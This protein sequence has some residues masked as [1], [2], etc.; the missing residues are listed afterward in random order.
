MFAKV[1]SGMDWLNVKVSY[2]SE[3]MAVDR[4]ELRRCLQQGKK[5]VRLED[6]SFA[7]FDPDAVRAMLDREIELLTTR[8]AKTARSRSPKAG[9]VQELLQHAAARL[10]VAQSARE[11]FQRLSS[12]EEIDVAKKPRAL[13][14]TLRPFVSRRPASRGSS[15]S[16]TSGSGKAS[17]PT[18]WVSARRFKRSPSFSR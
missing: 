13:K 10:N 14:A 11:L 4:D 8:A 17:S 18:T 5:F 9:R 12:I 1:T 2:E 7:A 6:G 3:G 15:S 16:T